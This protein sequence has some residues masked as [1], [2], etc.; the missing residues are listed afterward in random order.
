MARRNSEDVASLSRQELVVVELRNRMV[1]GRLTPG[2]QLPHRVALAKEFGVSGVTIQRALDQLAEEGHVH[3]VPG[4][5]TFVVEHP[6]YRH[7]FGLVIPSERVPTEWQ[8]SAQWSHF[9]TALIQAAETLSRVGPNRFTVY[10]GLG[11]HS[12]V[13]DAARLRE[14]L[15]AARLAGLFLLGFR[16]QLDRLK[17]NLDRTPCISFSAEPPTVIPDMSSFFTGALDY[18]LARGRRQVAVLLP[19]QHWEHGRQIEAIFAQY[20]LSFPPHRKQF[21]WAWGNTEAI[22]NIVLLML[23]GPK[24]ERPDGLIIADDHLVTDATIGIVAS[25][26]S[27]PG[28]LEVVAHANFPVATVSHVP[29]LRRGFDAEAM[30]LAAV[31]LAQSG[32]GRAE[33][34][35]PAVNAEDLRHNGGMDPAL[36]AGSIR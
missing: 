21:A 14:D 19:H 31:R 4:K 28:D 18:L 25:G 8:R 33:I 24:E 6:H 26:R 16:F 3:A 36:L 35:I 5:G 23:R 7:R 27:V 29:T 15:A 32:G 1:E 10:Y 20:G 13:P 11:G 2:S 12:D 34:R 30:L 17:L 22:R 9:W